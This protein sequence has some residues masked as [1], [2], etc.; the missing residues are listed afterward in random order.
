VITALASITVLAFMT[1]LPLL[2]LWFP[3]AGS[4]VSFY[5]EEMAAT[6]RFAVATLSI[7]PRLA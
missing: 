7:S 2:D 5:I 1:M 6:R 4:F 3:E